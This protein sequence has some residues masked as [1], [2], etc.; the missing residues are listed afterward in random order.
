[1][2]KAAEFTAQISATGTV[3]I[4][5]AVR[6]ELQLRPNVQVKVVLLRAE[7]TQ[8]EKERLAAERVES[9]RLMEEVRRE[10]AG[11]DF[12][13]TEAVLE[14]RRQEDGTL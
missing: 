11:K 8:E 5:A 7:D 12:N 3:T 13:A 14:A 9:W 2:L 4:P 1:M 10:L 6:Q